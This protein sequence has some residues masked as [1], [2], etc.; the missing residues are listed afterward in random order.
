[1]P[2]LEQ[3]IIATVRDQVSPRFAPPFNPNKTQC[4]LPL[5]PQQSCAA[6][7]THA[8]LVVDLAA[9][10][11]LVSDPVAIDFGP[12]GRLWVA[13][14]IDYP[15]G[16]HGNYE[17]GGRIRVLEDTRG[18]GRF[19]KA[20]IFLDNIPFPT[21]IK[22]WRR[23][24]LVC[25]A[26]DILYAEDT[27]RDGKADVVRKLYSGFGT[28]NYQARVNS[29]E[30]GLDGW[31]YGSCGLFGGTIQSFTGKTLALG[32]R[33]FRIK[34]DTGAIEPATGRTQQGRV[35][36]DWGNW[37][38]CDNSNLCVH[39]VL[40]DHYLR[41]NPHTAPI[42]TA[43][44]VND[45]ADANRLYPAK[46]DLQMFKL[47]GPAYHTTSACGIGIYRDDFLGAD[48]TGN[49]FTCEPVN[50]LVHRLRLAPRGSTFAGRRPAEET[51][52]EFLSSTDNWSRPVQ[53]RTGPDGALW[54]V[55]M[56]RFV[57]EHPRWIPASE[58]ALLD[59]RAGQSMGRIYRVLPRA[60]QP[61]PW[62]RLDRLDAK[63][64]VAALDSPNG[65]QRDMAGQML[66]WT[67]AKATPHHETI[68][69]LEELIA[70]RPRAEARLQALCVLE[71]LH[72]LRVECVRKALNDAHPGIRRQAVRLAEPFLDHAPPLA[73]MVAK[74]AHDA[75]AQV[76]LQVAYSLGAWHEGRA[77][78]ALATMALAHADDR[79]LT[80]AVFSSLH[81][82]NI[83][84]ALAQ[85]S[86]EAQVP[87][88][89]ARELFGLAAALNDGK[90]LSLFFSKIVQQ[91]G[92]R[93][94]PWQ[95]T[96]VGGM[97]ETWD[98]QGQGLDGLVKEGQGVLD[99]LRFARRTVADARANEDLRLAAMPLLGRQLAERPGDI[100]QL[101]NVL[102]ARNSAAL[103]TTAI[104]V[105]GRLDDDR[106][107][108]TVLAGWNGHSP[109]L[110]VQILD[111]LLS[112]PRWQRR[113]LQALE[114]KEVPPAQVDLA[115]R[116]RLQNHSDAAI[117]A[118]AAR[119]FAETSNPDRRKV[120]QDYADVAT[121]VGDR[122]R[123]KAVFLKSCSACHLVDGI[124]HA[125]GPDLAQ[126]AGK[127][128]LY[129]L[130][131][132]L[133]PNRNVDTRYVEYQAALKNGQTV[134]GLLAAETA[135]SITL[136]GQDAK[137]Q[138]ILRA[139][140]EELH[141][142]GKSLMPEGF[143]RDLSKQAMADLIAYLAPQRPAPKLIQ[144]RN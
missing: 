59:V 88:T 47:S 112:R 79:F 92:G 90:D 53:L 11:P 141:G 143:E 27:R 42:A 43:F 136:R 72:A 133:D 35:R 101:Q 118:L 105:L 23:G 40:A 6:Y 2:G 100:T 117:R 76:R 85:V 46:K 55:D 81:R 66:V 16:R 68:K 38:G 65:W 39:Y 139:D 69:L 109:A 115:R 131:E 13:E 50:L 96:A 127:S 51:Q 86:T 61:R 7:V 24:V 144:D 41:R 93:F 33:D 28:Q 128:S 124:G 83:G 37:F 32:D 44:H 48:W 73:L 97:L 21:G 122:Q 57:I 116:Q 26:P 91:Q 82:G 89:L 87:A 108:G 104:R 107:P 8:D 64:L 30:Y 94:A 22:V 130:T 45:Y 78:E 119:L 71:G 4:T 12:D 49:A 75:D 95:L 25:A 120:L 142:T 52:S 29:L 138:I 77:G 36:D 125:V 5:S 114:K 58:L 113:L 20:T 134:N 70:D 9:A 84:A 121:M 132:I 140:I 17:P 99:V 98:R 54:V 110:K 60:K 111:L 135:T 63:G 15:A 126:V 123:G 18:S 74:M 137:E 14:M 103:Q 62:L 19:D 34:P 1:M 67:N 80:A 3:P 56:Y 106:V 10:E 31:V 102:V 129:L